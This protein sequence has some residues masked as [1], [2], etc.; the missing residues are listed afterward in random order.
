MTGKWRLLVSLLSAF[1]VNASQ[2]QEDIHVEGR[3]DPYCGSTLMLSEI[4]RQ[5]KKIQTHGVG[6]YV[7]PEAI[8]DNFT[9]CQTV[10]LENGHKLVTKHYKLGKLS[11]AKGQEPKDVEP[12]FCMYDD[13]NLNEGTSFNLERCPKHS[14]DFE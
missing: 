10:W 1:A 7:F 13:G 14:K 4:E 2:A 5:A 9:G 6:F 12:F 3:L 8:P 11:W